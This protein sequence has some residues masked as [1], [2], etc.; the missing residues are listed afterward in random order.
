MSDALEEAQTAPDFVSGAR[1][2]RKRAS[3]ARP[4]ARNERRKASEAA[5]KRRAEMERRERRRVNQ[6]AASRMKKK[7]TVSP[8]NWARFIAARL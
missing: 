8:A 4:A 1:G 6:Y 7:N 5:S 2:K 3:F